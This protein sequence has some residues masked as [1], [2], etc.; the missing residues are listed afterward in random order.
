M[1][2][3]IENTSY[4]WPFQPFRQSISQNSPSPRN[5]PLHHPT[6]VAH[7]QTFSLVNHVG[8]VHRQPPPRVTHQWIN[9]GLQRKR[10]PN[11]AR[12]S[13]E[14]VHIYSHLSNALFKF[15]SWREA[16]NRR[17]KRP[18]KH[19]LTRER[20]R[21]SESFKSGEPTIASPRWSRAKWNT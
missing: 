18:T 9:Q 20:E 5:W 17:W 3:C 15:G 7:D 1:C 13:G 14:L 2:N 19:G 6:T 8:L 21:E 11:P 4:V 12:L 10:R 16:N